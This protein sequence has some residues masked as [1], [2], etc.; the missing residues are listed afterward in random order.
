MHFGRRKVNVVELFVFDEWQQNKSITHC[1][2]TR[3]GGVSSGAF[4]SMNLGFNRNDNDTNVLCNYEI[5]AETLKVDIESFVTAQQTHTKNIKFVT[6]SDCGNGVTK[7]NK[8]KDV[9]GI[10]TNEKGVTLVT[11]YADCVPLF[12]YA[13]KAEVIGMAHAG[14]KGTFAEIGKEMAMSF[15]KDFNI[16]IDEIEVGIG[17]SICKKCFEVHSD[18]SDIFLS[19]ELF[20]TCVT[21]NNKKDK[22]N[23]DLWECNKRSLESIGIKKIYVA[24]LCTCCN[25]S[26][27]FSHRRDGANRGSAAGFI[28]LN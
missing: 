10:Y 6:K 19:N 23:I 17:P 5:M 1:Y 21:K 16:P 14:W 18:V 12:F 26:L 11:H 24:E 25:K 27:F 28:A 3:K 13:P 22:F 9:D 2:S 4:K 7:P 15:H 20:K 8:F